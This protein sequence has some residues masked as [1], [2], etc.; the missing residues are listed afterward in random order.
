MDASEAGRL[1]RS[2][3]KLA[4]DALDRLNN[5]DL[6]G[7]A[8]KMIVPKPKPSSGQKRDLFCL[9]RD[10]AEVDPALSKLWEQANSVPEWV[11]WRQISRGQDVFY[12][13]GGP[14]LTGGSTYR[15]SSIRLILNVE[16]L[17]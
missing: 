6:E 16:R 11:D 4:D 14:A 9:L 10:N 12:R 7:L 13:Y 8:R 3:D 15:G 2:W 17:H 1:K 5:L